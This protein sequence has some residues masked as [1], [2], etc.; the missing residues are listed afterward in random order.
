MMKE[1]KLLILEDVPF[2]VELIERELYK[3]DIKFTSVIVDREENYLDE[4]KEFKPDIILADHSLPHF[5]GLSALEIAKKECPD[6]P[7][8]FVSGKI[9]EEFAV[10]ALKSG[11]TDYVFKGNLPKIVHAIN[12]ALEEVKEQE[13]LE[14]AEKELIKSHEFLTEAQKIGKMGSWEYDIAKNSVK[15]SN[16][17]FNI[18]NT[19]PTNNSIN[20]DEFLEIIHPEDIAFVKENIK[21]ALQDKNTFSYEYRINC[22]DN[23]T[24]ILSC[25]GKVIRN[26]NNEPIRIIG[27]EQDIT[28]RKIS[29]NKLKESLEEKEMLLQEIHH[30]VKNNLQVIYSLLR[31]QSRFIQ[32]EKSQEIFKETQNRIRSIAVLHEKLYRSKDLGRIGFADY[33]ISL[34]KDLFHSYGTDTNLINLNVNIENI[35]LNIE[36]A[37]PCGIIINELVTN[38]LKHAFPPGEDGNITIETFKDKNGKITLIVR[39]DGIGIPESIDINNIE[40]LGLQLVQYLT[41]RIKGEIFLNREKG[42]EIKI[43]FSEL[44]YSE[45]T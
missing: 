42:T 45:R 32:D 36:T 14:S 24:K 15:C 35:Y 39:D 1:L 6:V 34:V 21:T 5:D 18:L 30:R 29:E 37:I 44:E 38:S 26:D 19:K 9:G 23:P 2:D 27:T 4:I 41:N 12:R 25:H 8:I 31:L 22:A 40:S 13:K 11:A 7:F 16:E 17:L 10:E 20:F 28:N 43:I 33:V 3:A